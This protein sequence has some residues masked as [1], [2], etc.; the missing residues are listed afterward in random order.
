MESANYS[1][2]FA[3]DKGG[4][5]AIGMDE[6]RQVMCQLPIPVERP[7]SGSN[8]SDNN[9]NNGNNNGNDSIDSSNP[10]T[11]VDEIRKPMKQKDYHSLRV[12][13]VV[14]FA[15]SKLLNDSN[16]FAKW[17]ADDI[18]TEYKSMLKQVNPV[19]LEGGQKQWQLKKGMHRVAV[20]NDESKGSMVSEVVIHEGRAYIV[21]SSLQMSVNGDLVEFA[22]S[23][24]TYRVV[25]FSQGWQHS[26]V[27][28]ESRK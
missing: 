8:N 10:L 1:T 28:V 9:G 26:L 22:T 27:I 13:G 20:L 14:S 4:L 19:I 15:V 5:Y 7:V 16:S 21:P 2:V 23:G 25:D 11:R 12:N 17:S 24:G 6:S 18:I 3:C